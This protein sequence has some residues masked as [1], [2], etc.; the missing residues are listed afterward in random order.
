VNA[1]TKTT[2]IMSL[3]AEIK[4]CEEADA[5]LAAIALCFIC[6]DAMA[7]AA[8]P[9]HQ[10]KNT[11]QDFMDW[12]DK[13][14][15]ADMQQPY[16]YDGKD[17]WAARCGYLHTFSASSDYHEKHE[18]IV[19]LSYHDGTGHIFDKAI[20][21]D[22]VVLGVQSFSDDIT[23]AVLAF[24]TEANDDVDRQSVV[25]HRLDSFF[26]SYPIQ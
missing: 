17:I 12:V 15:K 25:T 10:T 21:P 4:K 2:G 19:T 24:L 8:M 9:P 20:T 22:L 13:Y 1:E 14:L 5:T 11:G 18:G 3:I 16:Q 26:A 7:Y 23:K 6:I